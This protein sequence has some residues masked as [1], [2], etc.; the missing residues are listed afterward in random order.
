MYKSN[1]QNQSKNVTHQHLLNKVPLIS[2]FFDNT[3]LDFVFRRN[4]FSY[5]RRQRSVSRVVPNFSPKKQN[6]SLNSFISD[7]LDP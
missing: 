7:N 3:A 2:F 4:A 1:L 6:G 5:F